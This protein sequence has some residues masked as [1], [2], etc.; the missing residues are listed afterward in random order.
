M[1]PAL[2]FA[3]YFLGLL[4]MV[5]AILRRLG[6]K[7]SFKIVSAIF[8][9]RIGLGCAY[10]YLFSNLYHGDDT[11]VFFGDSLGETD[12]LIHHP[13]TFFGELLPYSA[14]SQA[15]NFWQ[16][17]GFYLGD[18]E[19]ASMVKLLALF[20]LFSGRNYYIDVLFFD[21]LTI[22]G[23]FLLYRLLL[24]QFPDKQRVLLLCLFFIPTISFWISGIR[25][26]GLLLLAMALVLYYSTRWFQRRRT[27]Y[28]GFVLLGMAAMLVYRAEFLWVMIPGFVGWTLTWQGRRKPIY[29][30]AFTYVLSALIFFGSLWLSPDQNLATPIW[31]KQQQYFQL[32]ARTRYRLDRLE[33]TPRGVLR[34]LPQA[35]ANGFLRPFFWEAK[36]PWQELMSLESMAFLALAGFFAIHRA[37]SHSSWQ[38]PSLVLFFI[39]YGVSLVIAIGYVVPFPGAIVRYRAIPELLLVISM[40]LGMDRWK[41]NYLNK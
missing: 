11:W 6:F 39:F 30:F 21:S 25:A 37:R 3:C 27:Y 22:A 16:G 24:A 34:L 33:T 38:P 32:H 20:N 1:L 15:K 29:Y 23:P 10:G 14:F 7:L 9:F 40:A 2:W 5:Q 41:S 13:L 28:L 18:L 8:V 19:Y 36:G 17:L 31:K 4:F 35:T 26:E 12:K